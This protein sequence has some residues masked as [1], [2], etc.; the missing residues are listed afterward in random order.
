MGELG[1]NDI[2]YLFGS[3][4]LKQNFIDRKKNATRSNVQTQ[5]KQVLV[6][7]IQKKTPTVGDLLKAL[8]KAHNKN[9]SEELQKKWGISKE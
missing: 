3:L 8:E 7:W 4:G 2:L 5:A 1:Q 9:A 6:G